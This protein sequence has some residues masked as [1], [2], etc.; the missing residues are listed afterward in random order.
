[1]GYISCAF[2]GIALEGWA[3]M[4]EEGER[5]VPL[6]IVPC[7]C[8]DPGAIAKNYDPERISLAETE[9]KHK[10]AQAVT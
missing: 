9:K 4:G 8:H 1:M 5:T 2:D 10:D 3:E 6:G 7:C